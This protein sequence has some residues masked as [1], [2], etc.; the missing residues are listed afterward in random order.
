MF[1]TQFADR[2]TEFGTQFA[3]EW[4][5]RSLARRGHLHVIGWLARE[6][7]GVNPRTR[8]GPTSLAPRPESHAAN[9]QGGDR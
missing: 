2:R 5:P 4:S 6:G 1:F 8:F 7:I 3:Y 9:E